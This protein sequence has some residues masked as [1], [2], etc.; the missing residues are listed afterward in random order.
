MRK[1]YITT[2]VLS[3]L[4]ALLSQLP[5]QVAWQW[6]APQASE[7]GIYL[8]GIEGRLNDGHARHATIQGLKLDSPKWDSSILA[9]LAAQLRMQIGGAID[10]YPVTGLLKVSPY[11]G[12]QVSQ[13]EGAI[14]LT[15]LIPLLQLPFAPLNGVLAL[16]IDHLKAG[17]TRVTA[18]DG[19][20][21][22][23]AAEWTLMKPGV[24]LGTLKAELSTEDDVLIAVLS[25]EGPLELEGRCTLTADNQYVAE[26]RLRAARAADPR[27]E[28]LLKTLGRPSEGWYRI[29]YKGQLPG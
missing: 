20:V 18:I 3:F 24:P 16:D 11:G 4:Y 23:R 21:S 25:S 27:L 22:L 29:N 12:T 7:Q 13:L 9:L 28:N 8:H 2:A 14:P 17:E 5:A 15:R 10:D 19:Q 26:I 6:Y 1:I